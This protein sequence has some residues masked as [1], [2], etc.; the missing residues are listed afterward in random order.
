MFRSWIERAAEVALERAETAVVVRKVERRLSELAESMAGAPQSLIHGQYFAANVLVE[1]HEQRV[2]VRTVDW[3]TAGR[4]PG[5]LDLAALVC[6]WD[7]VGRRELI[8]A[9]GDARGLVGTEQL[10][11]LV[12]IASVALAVQWLGWVHVGEPPP[13]QTR[14]WL[15]EA[16]V[17]MERLGW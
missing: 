1:G 17:A 16:H 7:E 10:T 3:E 5:V 13:H 6:G 9:Y 11:E 12:D 8:S 2:R 4:G 14:N 15:Q